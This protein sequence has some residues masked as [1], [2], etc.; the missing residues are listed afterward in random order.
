MRKNQIKYSYRTC[1]ILKKMS[2][3]FN[4]SIGNMLIPWSFHSNSLS[5]ARVVL[6]LTS[7]RR[8]LSKLLYKRN[9]TLRQKKSIQRMS[10]FQIHWQLLE[11]HSSSQEQINQREAKWSDWVIMV[12]KCQRTLDWSAMLRLRKRWSLVNWHRKT[13]KKRKKLLKLTMLLNLAA[14]LRSKA[15]MRMI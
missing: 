15:F 12:R 1:K 4:L 6:H 5:T 7:R 8:P 10:C 2:I 9:Q 3:R 13:F 11:V 14:L